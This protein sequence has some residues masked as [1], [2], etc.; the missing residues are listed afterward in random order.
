MSRYDRNY[1]ML[2]PTDQ[3]K[4]ADSRVCVIGCGG[5]GGYV[6]EMLA[7]LGVGYLTLVDGDV[8]DET[9]L[10]RQVLSTEANLGALK[11]RVASERVKAINSQISVVEHA[12]FFKDENA[13]DLISGHD[14]VVD[15]LDKIPTR[16][17]LQETCKSLNVPLIHGAIGG[18][19]GQVSV[20]Y[21]GDDTLSKLY[22]EGSD[23]GVEK[24]L[25]NPSFTPAFVASIEVSECLKV[26]LGKEDQVLRHKVM[27]I[28]LLNHQYDIFEFK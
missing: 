20:V 3:I 1:K 8:F 4:L 19:Y 17:L 5:L 2:T 27:F 23:K 6:I 7:R 28:D 25:G 14:V 10:N 18:W 26:L 16:L 15:A 22:A 9:N 24:D 13:M 12:V 11:A 21:P